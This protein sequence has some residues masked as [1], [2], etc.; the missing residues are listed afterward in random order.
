MHGLDFGTLL[1]FVAGYYNGWSLFTCPSCGVTLQGCV[2]GG[3]QP[4]YGLL[5]ETST[6]G[7]VGNKLDVVK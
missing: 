7:A 4:T 3:N 5:F 2:C 6:P 1:H